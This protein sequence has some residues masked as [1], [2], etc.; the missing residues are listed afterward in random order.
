MIDLNNA[1]A[2]CKHLIEQQE[3]I[4]DLSEIQLNDFDDL[5]DKIEKSTHIK[6][7]PRT[8]YRLFGKGKIS[9]DRTP[10]KATRQA[11]ALFLGFKD[12]QALELDFKQQ[13]NISP[14]QYSKK[15]RLVN[16]RLLLFI[17]ITLI[18]ISLSYFGL[19][20][21]TDYEKINVLKTLELDWKT[22]GDSSPVEGVLKYKFDHKNKYRLH[23]HSGG[24][25][26][27]F[28]RDVI[29]TTVQEKEG[30]IGFSYI[31]PDIYK[32]FVKVYDIDSSLH[33][34][35]PVVVKSQGWKASTVNNHIVKYY[36]QYDTYN[37]DSGY[38]ELDPGYFVEDMQNTDMKVVFSALRNAQDFSVNG[39]S[40]NISFYARNSFY[41]NSYMQGITLF[42]HC[43]S[44][45]LKARYSSPGGG[46]Y[47]RIE[48]GEI[49]KQG[50]NVDLTSLSVL[51]KGWNK[52]EVKVH[53]NKASFWCNDKKLMNQEYKKDLGNLYC[54]IVEF[55][56]FGQIREFTIN[57]K[58]IN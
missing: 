51:K 53:K 45:N 8:L 14:P 13:H 17:P 33:Y 25:Y 50:R 56:E 3:K 29:R 20:A 30:V 6:L 43:S 37:A 15:S 44:R 34:L 39:D 31:M 35:T 5:A 1:L 47:N 42:A 2:Y 57:N 18:L 40:M 9:Q 10:Q 21:Y 49:K 27:F 23:F 36:P 41:S 4:Y 22:K 48:V 16:E 26:K 46:K 32:P 12:W 28:D 7:S 55:N 38:Y 24:G 19:E 52:I 58:L 11:L 54:I